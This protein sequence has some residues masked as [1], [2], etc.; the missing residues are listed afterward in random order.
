MKNLKTFEDA[1]LRELLERGHIDKQERSRLLKER[2]VKKIPILQGTAASPGLKEADLLAVLAHLYGAETAPDN[3]ELSA[4]ASP[5]ADEVFDTYGV[6]LGDTQG[7]PV[8]VYLYEPVYDAV[9]EQIETKIGRPLR[10][11]TLSR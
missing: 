7:N 5:L 2:V 10:R 11:M 3:A 4:S 6:I 9:W 8:E 1:L